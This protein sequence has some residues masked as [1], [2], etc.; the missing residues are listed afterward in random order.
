MTQERYPPFSVVAQ[1]ALCEILTGHLDEASTFIARLDNDFGNLK[2]DERT[3]LHCR[4]EIAKDRF[5]ECL[6]LTDRFINKE[7]RYYK[8]IRH[9]ALSGELVGAQLDQNTREHYQE[10][11]NALAVTLGDDLRFD[12]PELDKGRF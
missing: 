12:I 2:R 6:R 3:G 4:L 5:A 8:L 11:F 9:D 10:E 1:V 7:S